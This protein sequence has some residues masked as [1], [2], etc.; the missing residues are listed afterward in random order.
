MS[1]RSHE[2]WRDAPFRC[3]LFVIPHAALPSPNHCRARGTRLD[4]YWRRFAA[5]RK[6]TRKIVIHAPNAPQ[7][8]EKYVYEVTIPTAHARNNNGLPR[9][10]RG[11][12]KTSNFQRVNAKSRTLEN[13]RGRG[14]F[15][16][17]CAISG[18]SR[19]STQPRRNLRAAASCVASS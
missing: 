5:E 10:T 1:G 6:V 3:D 7:F 4:P 2:A 9:S 14:S 16:R 19:Y 17:T 15:P 18:I 8:M 13:S 12:R 11:G